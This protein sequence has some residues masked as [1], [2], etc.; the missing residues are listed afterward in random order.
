[1][2]FEQLQNLVDVYEA[3]EDISFEEVFSEDLKN[4]K[5]HAS[6]N[7]EDIFELKRQLQ[8]HIQSEEDRINNEERRNIFPYETEDIQSEQ[9]LGKK[10]ATDLAP[11]RRRFHKKYVEAFMINI[12]VPKPLGGFH[13]PFKGPFSVRSCGF[14]SW[15]SCS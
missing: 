13:I 2:Q 7:K 1:M 8:A 10:Q 9:Q 3:N 5:E 14:S 15:E 11:G 6:L 12:S 4:S